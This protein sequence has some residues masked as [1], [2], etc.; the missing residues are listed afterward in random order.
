M[1][2]RED[3]TKS[4]GLGPGC[5]RSLV[6]TRERRVSQKCFNTSGRARSRSKM[7]GASGSRRS[8][9]FH[10]SH[11]AH[12]RLGN[13]RRGLRM[14]WG[15]EHRWH[16]KTF[17]LKSQNISLQSIING[18]HNQWTAALLHIRRN[19][20]GYKDETCKTCGK[21]G[22][23]AKICRVVTHRQQEH[24]SPKGTGKG[25]G[26]GPSKCKGKK[27]TPDTVCDVEKRKVGHL[28]EVC[29][30][31]NTHEIEKDAHEPSPEVTFEA[32]WCMA[33]RDTVG[34]GHCDC[35]EKHDVSSENRDESEFTEFPERRDEFK[36]RKVITNI[37]TDQNSGKS[38]RTSR[39]VKFRKSHHEHRDKSQFKKKS[40]RTSRQ[41]TIQEKSSRTS[42]WVNRTQTE[43]RN[44]DMREFLQ[45]ELTD[46]NC[47]KKYSM[48]SC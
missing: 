43:D 12:K 13:L 2:V 34:D 22:H 9:S 6:E 40:S 20:C 10:K 46:Q 17:R 8:R 16:G 48:N 24:G 14:T 25:S 30:I 39:R 4:G 47:S 37:E 31:T 26:K 19:D 44:Q 18:H 38:S 5:A 27:R 41:V 35:I 1:I 45:N 42:K 33:G 15:S 36:V 32:V 7:C 3:A 29:R 21:R 11:K 23:V 28:R